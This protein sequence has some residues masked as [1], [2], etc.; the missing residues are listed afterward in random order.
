MSRVFEQLY[1][2]IAD[3]MKLFFMAWFV[4]MIIL[5]ASLNI[6]A[7]RSVSVAEAKGVFL[8]ADVR[9]YL[10]AFNIDESKVSIES[11]PYWG[12]AADFLGAPIWIRITYDLDIPVIHGTVPITVTVKKMGINQ[13]YPGFSGYGSYDLEGS[14]P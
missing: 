1:D 14:A 2:V 4:V 10:N 9:H 12:Q 6:A 5:Y 8:H 13:F 7:Y 3:V 11:Q